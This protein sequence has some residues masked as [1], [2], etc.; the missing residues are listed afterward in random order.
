VD[1]LN[2]LV[3]HE[4]FTGVKTGSDRAAGGCLLFTRQ[5][6]V[7]GRRLTVVGAVLGQRQGA[8]IESA[9][10]SARNLGNTAAAAVQVHTALPAGTPSSR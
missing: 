5:V 2:A 4:G 7:A 1:N 6:E 3:G 10:A 9:L 8:W